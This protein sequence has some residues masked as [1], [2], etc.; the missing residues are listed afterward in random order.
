VPKTPGEPRRVV[1]SPGPRGADV[2]YDDIDLSI[3]TDAARI[4]DVWLIE[5]QAT[6]RDGAP[7]SAEWSLLPAENGT[8]WRVVEFKGGRTPV[9]ITH[10]MHQTPTVD[11]GVILCGRISLVLEDA[12]TV[13]LTAGDFF[14]LR[15]VQH[16]WANPGRESCVM[17]IVLVRSQ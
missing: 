7:G 11:M 14:V 8:T 10:G 6:A 13:E 16:T 9:D 17:S 15:G 3:E 12:S 5:R 2:A 4:S 1:V